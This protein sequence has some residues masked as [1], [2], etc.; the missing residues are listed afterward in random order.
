MIKMRILVSMLNF[1]SL[2]PHNQL[3]DIEIIH[4]FKIIY[5]MALSIQLSPSFYANH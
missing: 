4:C 5:S 1:R 3:L 2:G